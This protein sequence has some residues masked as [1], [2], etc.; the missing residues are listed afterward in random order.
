[1]SDY[2]KLQKKVENALDE[3][4]ELKKT[5]LKGDPGPQGAK[6]DKGDKGDPGLQGVK[7]E[8]GLKGDPG[9]QGV[10][11]E[12]GDK[13][14]PGPQ[15][16]KGETG[17]KG[18]PGPQGVKGE[19]GDKGDPGPQGIKGEKGDPGSLSNLMDAVTEYTAESQYALP[20]SGDKLKTWLGKA[21]KALSDARDG[22]TGAVEYTTPQLYK[23]PK[24]GITLK[25]FMG[26]V[27]KG[28]AD[29]FAG[30]A[31]K[32]D[33]SKILSKEE[34]ST[35]ISERGYLADAKDI[36]DAITPLSS[37]KDGTLS[38]LYYPANSVKW[39][40]VGN[41]VTISN[42]YDIQ[43]IPAGGWKNIGT[44]PSD[45]RPKLSFVVKSSTNNDLIYKLHPSGIVS[46]YNYGNA[47]SGAANGAFFATYVSA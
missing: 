23:E 2:E 28:L 40:K 31:L 18:D 46:M 32:I 45:I 5:G 25:T 30:L 47:V 43:G 24:S 35:A 41:I 20:N 8:T 29:L 11:G 44:L 4:E 15:G 36:K 12:K 27:T 39:C 42:E 21:Q 22:E 19:K 13:G 33:A 3:V 6:G 34:W 9:P 10:K 1:M 38:F 7:G 37:S 14:D 16:I 26:R 17:L